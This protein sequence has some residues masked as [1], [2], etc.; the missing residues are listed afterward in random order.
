MMENRMRPFRGLISL[1]EAKRIAMEN[2]PEIT[3]IEVIGLLD[4]DGRMLA[5]DIE[6][7]I[8][9][10]PYSRSA[11]DGYAVRAEDTYGAGR[12]S[13]VKLR[14]TE[15][16]HAGEVP[17]NELKKGEAIQIATGAMI[18]DGA[19]AIVMVEH[20]EVKGDSVLVFKP[21]YPGSD[22]SG[23]GED[24]KSGDVVL[25]AGE[26]LSPAKVG[27]I[28]SLGITE[29]KVFARPKIAVIPTG[30][31][32][33]APGNP[34]DKGKIYDINTY[35]L[36][37]IARELGADV[38]TYPITPDRKEDIRNAIESALPADIILLSGG[39]SVGERDVIVDVLAEMGEVL[40]HGIQLKPGKPTVCGRITG[41][42]GGKRRDTLVFGMPG[43][44][45]SCLTNAYV[46][47][48]PLIRKL[49]GDRTPPRVEKKRMS[50]RIVSTLGRHQI[51][52]VRVDGDTAYPAFKESGAITSMANAD[53][54]IQIPAN[55]DLVEKGEMVDVTFF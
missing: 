44:P 33:T 4:A 10:P 40:F 50:H 52:T 38:E 22:V 2:L 25:K 11:V 42:Y 48:A 36:S 46:L 54:Y 3:D 20:T 34:L 17:E 16:V 29:I 28:S 35:T 43:Y 41:E 18:P 7:I 49:T 15:S 55:V 14:I 45:T 13:P 9:V 39:S 51:F 27:A 6:A 19:D 24:I 8:D 21:S 5:E 1:E 12:Y 23:R 31:E 32:V 53:G 47:V 26:R 37:S 30:D